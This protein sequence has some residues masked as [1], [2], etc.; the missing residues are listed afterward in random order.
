MQLQIHHLSIDLLQVPTIIF[1]A[2][3]Y[4]CFALV[5]TGS[6]RINSTHTHIL[7]KWIKLY[8]HVCIWWLVSPDYVRVSLYKCVPNLTFT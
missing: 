2:L 6:H 7:Y 5:S 4:L 1:K 8:T 3:P